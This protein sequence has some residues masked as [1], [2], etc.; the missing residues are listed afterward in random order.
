MYLDFGARDLERIITQSLI[1]S[2]RIFRAIF[3]FF[4]T[5]LIVGSR[6]AHCKAIQSPSFDMHGSFV[7]KIQPERT[8]NIRIRLG[9]GQAS[10]K[11]GSRS[12]PMKQSKGRD[13]PIGLGVNG[14]DHWD[15]TKP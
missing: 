12:N 13:H 7:R 4:F 14:P 10:G 6:L 11:T 1:N 15:I 8:A 2:G 3:F 5:I 9:L